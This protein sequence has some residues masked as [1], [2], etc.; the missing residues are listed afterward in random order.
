MGWLEW[1]W[2][3][4]S[5]LW[6]PPLCLPPA[7]HPCLHLSCIH[8]RAR[9]L[10]L[11]PWLLEATQPPSSSALG[12]QTACGAGRQIC[13]PRKQTVAIPAANSAALKPRDV[14]TTCKRCRRKSL[15]TRKV[16]HT[17]QCSAGV[18]CVL[19]GSRL[20]KCCALLLVP[21]QWTLVSAT[22]FHS[23]QLSV[24]AWCHCGYTL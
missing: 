2:Q 23:Q 21:M 18:R 3:T 19:A 20:G 22:S 15:S 1:S 24:L 13:H 14:S 11:A 16:V 10:V 17:L 4:P 7:V 6:C 9:G 5:L 8:Q 12:W